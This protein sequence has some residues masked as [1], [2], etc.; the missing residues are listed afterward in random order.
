MVNP[1]KVRLLTNDHY[2]KSATI[3]EA[4]KGA[5][6][7]KGTVV[8]VEDVVYTNG[9][10]PRLKISGNRYISGKKTYSEKIK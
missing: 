10:T 4:N 1:L 5:A 3:T 6:Y 2:Y 9:G 8:E 7:K